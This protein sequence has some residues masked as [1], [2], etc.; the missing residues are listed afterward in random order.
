[1]RIKRK[2]LTIGRK[3]KVRKGGGNELQRNIC[4]QINGEEFKE[5]RKFK[6][7]GLTGLL[8]CESEVKM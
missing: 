5:V 1:M 8:D 2:N 4:S 6:N 7:V 3:N